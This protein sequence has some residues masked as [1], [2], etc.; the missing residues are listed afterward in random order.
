MKAKTGFRK[1][2]LV[3]LADVYAGEWLGSLPKQALTLAK[4]R[5]IP[6]IFIFNGTLCRANPEDSLDSLSWWSEHQ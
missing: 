3:L 1:V 2:E 6:V 5:Q 4:K